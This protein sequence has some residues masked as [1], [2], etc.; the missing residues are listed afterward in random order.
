MCG[1]GQGGCCRLWPMGLGRSPG[2]GAGAPEGTAPAPCPCRGGGLSLGEE[3]QCCLGCLGQIPLH[4]AVVPA[5]TRVQPLRDQERR[6]RSPVRA[7]VWQDGQGM[8]VYLPWVCVSSSSLSEIGSFCISYCCMNFNR[9]QQ[10]ISYFC[11]SCCKES[12]AKFAQ[13]SFPAML[14][15]PSA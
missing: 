14:S 4:G 10:P 7:L 9:S 11:I 5:V 2:L 13:R 6:G 8:P 1:V 3:S 12:W 15:S